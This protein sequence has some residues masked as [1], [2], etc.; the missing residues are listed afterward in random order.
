MYDTVVNDERFYRAEVRASKGIPYGRQ[1]CDESDIDASK[2]AQILFQE[3]SRRSELELTLLSHHGLYT[4]SLVRGLH[5][6]SLCD[7]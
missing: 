4:R 6:A 2:A 7:S 5:Y 1:L 3:F